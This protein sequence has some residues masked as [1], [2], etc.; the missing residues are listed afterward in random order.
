[1]L[2]RDAVF[3]LPSCVSLVLLFIFLS[4]HCVLICGSFKIIDIAD[5]CESAFSGVA[6]IVS[7]T[8]AGHHD[9]ISS[10][11]LLKEITDE[12]PVFSKFI[13]TDR[14]AGCK[15]ADL[16]HVM[17]EELRSTMHAYILRRVLWCIG[18]IVVFIIIAIRTMDNY[19]SARDGYL[20]NRKSSSRYRPDTSRSRISV[21]RG[22]RRRV[23]RR[24]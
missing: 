20:R 12:Y 16:P 23:N 7:E 15:A 13:D 21:S 2:F 4:F 8:A 9:N 17:A 6:S 1:M 10:E 22:G 18:F 14:F 11:Q 19:G 24:R 5:Y 3:T